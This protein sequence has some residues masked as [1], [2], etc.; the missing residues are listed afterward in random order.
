MESPLTD[1]SG[2]LDRLGD[3]LPG[4]VGV[5]RARGL[6]GMLAL[7]PPLRALR[8]ALPNAQITLV[9][10]GWGR[11]FARRF[12]YYIDDYLEVP[13]FPDF[14]RGP[15]SI[16]RIPAF[17]QLAQ[18]RRFDLVLQLQGCS[19]AANV[20]A[21]LLGSRAIA[22]HYLKGQFCPD[23]RRY[24][25]YPVGEPDVRRSLHLLTWLGVA[26]KGTDLE[27]PILADDWT[28]FKH[29]L[30]GQ[31][32]ETF[33]YACLLAPGPE[34]MELIPLE[35]WIA[36]ARGVVARGMRVVMIGHPDNAETIQQATGSGS[37]VL[38]GE[39]AVGGL[40]ALLSG[41]R[42]FIG[43]QGGPSA[44]AEALRIPRLV[45][46][47]EDTV[48]LTGERTEAYCR[49][50]RWATIMPTEEILRQADD[51]LGELPF[52]ALTPAAE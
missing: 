3:T 47:L 50:L 27:F 15:V 46:H 37:L 24:M 1:R 18:S 29:A 30:A 21:Y 32:L 34:V 31:D 41:S 9:S 42:L 4:R 48:A 16:E 52:P 43:L 45:M 23:I 14:N 6:A 25:L 10:S 28:S 2:M 51:L 36:L 13:G 7:V 49:D 26:A 17:L 38:A 44:L 40:A 22:G 11:D 5:M 39:L 12:S 20:L 33:S 8:D 19:T 35:R